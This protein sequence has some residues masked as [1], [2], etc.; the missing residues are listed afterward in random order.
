M[1]STRASG[2]LSKVGHSVFKTLRLS[3]KN[4]ADFDLKLLRSPFTFIFYLE[5]ST[6]LKFAKELFTVEISCLPCGL[7]DDQ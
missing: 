4:W 1:G 2:K 3:E 6:R 7:R 5:V